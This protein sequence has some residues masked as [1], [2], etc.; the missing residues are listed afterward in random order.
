MHRTFIGKFADRLEQ[1]T[2]IKD[3]ILYKEGDPIDYVYIVRS[4]EFIVTRK[5]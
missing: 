5:K 4:G 1:K 2:C 3:Q